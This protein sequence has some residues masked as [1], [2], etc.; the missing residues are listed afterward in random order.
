MKGE[1]IMDGL[2][3][4]G[5]F[6]WWSIHDLLMEKPLFHSILKEIGLPPFKRKED[7]VAANRSA[8]LK[9]VREVKASDK[10]LLIRKISKVA[11]KYTFGLVD[12]SVDTKNDHLGYTHSATLTYIPSSGVLDCSSQHRGYEAVKDKYH[13]YAVSYNSDDIREYLLD[14]IKNQHRV[15]V[16]SRGGIYFLPEAAKDFVEKLEKFLEAL[17]G[18]CVLS[19]APQIDVETSKRAIYKAFVSELRQK[20]SGFREELE[21]D[22][23]KRK[24]AMQKRLEEFQELRKEVEFYKDA[25]QFQVDD[26]TEDL[27]ELEG[28]VKSRIFG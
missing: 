11:D 6:V 15:S 27:T 5:Y 9:A 22:S 13:K 21:S 8:F 10:K 3:I 23:L 20:L 19:V 7:V 18:D 2:T 26:L 24:S 1:K 25:L 17:P 14:A 12:E 16:R 28:T 4:I